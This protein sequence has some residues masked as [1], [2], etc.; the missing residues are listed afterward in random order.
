MNTLWKNVIVALFLIMAILWSMALLQNLGNSNHKLPKIQTNSPSKY[1]SIYEVL[2]DKRSKEETSTEKYNPKQDKSVNC[3]F[4]AKKLIVFLNQYPEYSAKVDWEA[5]GKKEPELPV[6]KL[7]VYFANLCRQKSCSSTR[8]RDITPNYK[9]DDPEYDINK[10]IDNPLQESD[11]RY[12]FMDLD[13]YIHDNNRGTDQI[14]KPQHSEFDI[15]HETN[16]YYF[17]EDGKQSD[18]YLGK[19]SKNIYDPAS[20]NNHYGIYGSS[21]SSNSVNNPYGTYGNPYSSH[22]ATNPYAIDAPKIYAPDGQY[23]GKYSANKFDYEST[24]NP[25][26]P[27][28]NPYS[29]TSINNPYSAYGNP[30]SPKSVNNPYATDAP[31]LLGDGK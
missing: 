8:T 2:G 9:P 14:Y 16:T 5:L 12:G 10:I 25:F 20:I 21:F 30:Y 13:S 26:G 11:S 28:G 31:S 15:N 7:K 1:N 18:S 4:A 27:Y 29:P 22:S 3:S 6:T 23:L 17:S 19:L 24:S